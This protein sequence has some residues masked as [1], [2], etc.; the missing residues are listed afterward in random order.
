VFFA[1]LNNIR[2][3][4][5]IKSKRRDQCGI[6]LLEKDNRRVT[7]IRSFCKATILNDYFQ[8]VFTDT[9]ST[10]TVTLEGN[11]FLHISPISITTEGVLQELHPY[12][13][14]GPHGMPSNCLR[15]ISVSIAP[16]LTLIM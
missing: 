5:Y 7:D 6:P 11:I 2:L 14:S 1:Y 8:F 12:K 16:S 4:S 10:P 9:N 13:V 15:E 3:W